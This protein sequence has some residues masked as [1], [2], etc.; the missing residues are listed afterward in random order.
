MRRT[1]DAFQAGLEQ[2]GD[3]VPED[4]QL[5]LQIARATG[6]RY[7]ADLISYLGTTIIPRTRI[8]SAQVAGDHL[9][10]YLNRINH[11][12]ED[13]YDAIARR[14]SEAAR[15]AMRN[16]LTNSRERLRRAYEAAES[17]KS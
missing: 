14:D 2:G 16:H 11:E 8:N 15:A 3:C 10:Q 6:N 7:F 4:F 5:H 13:I 17:R 1:L 9:V 12:H